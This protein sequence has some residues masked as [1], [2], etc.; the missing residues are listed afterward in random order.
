MLEADVCINPKKKKKK[1]KR[2]NATFSLLV[3]HQRRARENIHC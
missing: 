3:L 1:K 2:A